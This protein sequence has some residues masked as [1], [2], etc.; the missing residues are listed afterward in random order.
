MA[1]KAL[2]TGTPLSLTTITDTV[3]GL[4]ITQNLGTGTR[5]LPQAQLHDR[6]KGWLA[7][8]GLY[9]TNSSVNHVWP[10]GRTLLTD[11]IIT[12]AETILAQQPPA[13]SIM[14]LTPALLSGQIAA[15]I[16][17]RPPGI[18]TPVTLDTN[19]DGSSPDRVNFEAF[20][21][22][23]LQS[24]STQ[25][26]TDPGTVADLTHVLNQAWAHPYEI[27][28]RDVKTFAINRFGDDS[29]AILHTVNGWLYGAG[30]LGNP[31]RPGTPRHTRIHH[32]TTNAA[33]TTA[34]GA[35]P[36]Y[37]AATR[38]I[39]P[40]PAPYTVAVTTRA[41]HANWP[42]TTTTTATTTASTSTAA[43]ASRR[44]APIRGCG[45]SDGGV[46]VRWGGVGSHH[47]N[48]LNSVFDSAGSGL[49]QDPGVAAS[50]RRA[51]PAATGRD[52]T[53][54]GRG[55]RVDR[56]TVLHQQGLRHRSGH[57]LDDHQQHSDLPAG[58]EPQADPRSSKRGV[59]RKHQLRGNRR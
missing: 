55:E 47:R 44:G 51:N 19:P 7:A 29:P 20:I 53:R 38:Q 54:L 40:T 31:P 24:S 30:V 22:A 52:R 39:H 14:G 57:R 58:E 50:Q 41:I 48:V 59:H 34:A 5:K 18:T 27:T 2:I 33:A 36:D 1:W 28:E 32:A 17:A 16:L 35:T 23:V 56:S 45:G 9:S 11:A 25:P 43:T 15:A 21:T 37:T 49:V 46:R 6:A 12:H 3:K 42:P 4:G 8:V 26:P 13:S 10:S